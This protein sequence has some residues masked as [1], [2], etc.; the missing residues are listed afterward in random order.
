MNSSIL[1]R[2]QFAY[3]VSNQWGLLL[4]AWQPLFEAHAGY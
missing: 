3:A 4:H 2:D 1:V